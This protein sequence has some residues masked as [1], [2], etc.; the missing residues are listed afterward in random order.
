MTDQNITVRAI[1]HEMERTRDRLDADV[2]ELLDRLHAAHETLQKHGTARY[3][4]SNLSRRL[5]DV[6]ALAA[7][8]T[9]LQTAHGYASRETTNEG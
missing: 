9:A 8:L 3:F 5:G 4:D 1:A 2:V 6:I 7:Q